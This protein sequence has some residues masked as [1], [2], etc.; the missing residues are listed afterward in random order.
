MT[1]NTPYKLTP[2]SGNMSFGCLGP[3]VGESEVDS[4]D[5]L[6]QIEYRRR[7][8]L[9]RV[10][11]PFWRVI[12]FVDGTCL[13]ALALEW[14]IWVPI[15]LF[16]GIRYQARTSDKEPEVVQQLGDTDIDI[17]GGF[18]S[19]LLV[20]FVNQ[21]NSRFYDMYGLAKKVAGQ[22]QDVAG[23]ASTQLPPEDAKRMV[24]YMNAAHVLGYVGLGGPYSRKHF[25]EPMNKKHNLL[26][27]KELR[28]ILP[29][30]MD[31]GSAAFKEMVTW[32]QREVGRAR[33]AGHIDSIEAAKMH[34]HI[35]NIR[36]AMDGI[37]DFTDQPTHFFYIHF[38]CLLSALYLP[39]FAIDNAYSAGWGEDSDVSI[40]ILNGTIVLCQ[41][42]FV[43]GLRL[44]GQIM[45]D[46]FG[47][48]LEDLSVI[49]Y[50]STTI[51]NT[52]II[53]DTEL[54]GDSEDKMEQQY[55]ATEN[56]DKQKVETGPDPC[57]E[58]HVIA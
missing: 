47:L 54:D 18:L 44:L 1:D 23:L 43:V 32:C 41:S 24:R 37:Y 25:F 6:Q 40:E 12:T 46:P 9:Q 38:L 42:I 53:L 16:V 29:L 5:E 56:A 14:M 39:I 35:L 49:T 28:R 45:I 10:E 20:L 36:A 7:D 55:L 31:S 2:Q 3:R 17:L 34:E 52:K 4:W 22:I 19:F 58:A 48:D 26:T 8:I 27:P 11:L 57:L 51:V 15:L 33:K 13:K 21:T 50:V 30:D